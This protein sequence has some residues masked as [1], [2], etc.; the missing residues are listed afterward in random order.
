MQI[1]DIRFMRFNLLALWF[2][3]PILM[4]TK[5]VFYVLDYDNYFN[6]NFIWRIT[7]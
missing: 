1:N 6:K 7:I 4:F 5:S 2:N 3:Q